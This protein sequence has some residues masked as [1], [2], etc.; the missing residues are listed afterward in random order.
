MNFLFAQL[1]IDS[2]CVI[3]A[4]SGGRLAIDFALDYQKKVSSLVL[5][6]A[7]VGGFSYTN[8]FY[9]RGGYLPSDLSDTQQRLLYHASYDPYEIYYENTNAKKKAIELVMSNPRKLDHTHDNSN[10]SQTT[11]SYLRLN[12]IKVPV[13]ILTGEYDIPDVQAH[14]GVINAGVSNSKRIIIPKSGHLIPLEQPDLFNQI[15]DD[16]LK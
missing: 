10:R 7:V 2:A 16:F 3:G 15:V 14:A 5:V 13:L 6:G 8:H 1:N 4:S 11:P 12:E 9:T